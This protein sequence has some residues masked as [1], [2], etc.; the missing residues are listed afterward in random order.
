MIRVLLVGFPL[1][2]LCLV[3]QVAAAYWSVRNYM[4]QS[5]EYVP[6]SGFIAGCMPLVVAMLIMMAGTMVQ[7]V[8]W[9]AAF[10]LLGEFDESFAAIYHSTVNYASLGYG[11]IV[12]SARWKLLGAMEALNGVLMMGMTG[13]ALM[14]ILQHMIKLLRAE[15]SERAA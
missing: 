9:G 6:G 2:A 3:I 1:M 8:V 12:M 15:S 4:R 10:V 7:I 14:A 13:A 11:D 5:V